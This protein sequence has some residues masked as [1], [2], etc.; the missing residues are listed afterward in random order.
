[1]N[2]S[3]T[4][5]TVGN[6]AAALE[7]WAEP[8]FAESYDNVGL[9]IGDVTRHVSRGLVALDLTPAVVEEAVLCGASI[10]IT[11][12]PLF[13]HPLRRITA[14][15]FTGSMAL[16]LAEHRIALYSAHTNLD[17]APGGVS[18][19]LASLLGVEAPR[20][21]ISNSDRASGM[22][23]IGHLKQP[24]ALQD[25]LQR[26]ANRLHVRTL[27]YVGD[28]LEPIQTV[29]VCGGAGATLIP[30]ARERGAD[31]YVTADISYHRFFE[32]LR[33]DGACAMALVDAGHYETERHA[34]A[35][36]CVMLQERFPQVHW[37]QTAERTSPIQSFSS[38]RE[39]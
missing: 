26:I 37:M 32:V 9:H 2:T 19:A 3:K 1:M 16:R 11:H 5:P 34:E 22:G 17:S 38:A 27:R 30:Q 10:I 7:E 14:D 35:L 13:F 12:H 36:L 23:A 21:L 31:V 4:L 24:L 39:L 28:D 18:C 33:P 15:D 6:V 8:C 20:F 25:F 29:A